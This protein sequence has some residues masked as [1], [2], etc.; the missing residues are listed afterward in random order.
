MIEEYLEDW[1]SP[2]SI[3]FDYKFHMFGEKCAHITIIERL[4]NNNS[5]ENKFWNVTEDWEALPIQF[6]RTQIPQETLP[7]KPDCWDELCESA[8]KLGSELGI[9]MRIDFFA[10]T[11]GAVFGEF[12]PQP[13]GGKGFTIEADKWL[14][15]I[16]KGKEGAGD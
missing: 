1:N 15:S 2:D 12:T 4:S 3:P 13:H 6:V 11:R 9:F 5:K 8:K 7:P 14:G 10:T 16:W